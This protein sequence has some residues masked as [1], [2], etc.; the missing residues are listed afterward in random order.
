MNIWCYNYH[1][2][3]HISIF[4]GPESKVFFDISRIQIDVTSRSLMYKGNF[5][6]IYTSS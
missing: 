2:H 6:V 3:I 4:R 1:S 5:S